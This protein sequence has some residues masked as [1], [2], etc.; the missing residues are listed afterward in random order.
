MAAEESTD[1]DNPCVL[2]GAAS[3]LPPN[4]LPGPR[5][6]ARAGFSEQLS[7]CWG[8]VGVTS[9][10]MVMK[11]LGL[12]VESVLDSSGLVRTL[13]AEL[14]HWKGICYEDKKCPTPSILRSCLPPKP[15]KCLVRVI[16]IA[17]SASSFLGKCFEKESGRT[18]LISGAA[19]DP[20]S[21]RSALA[22]SSLPTKRGYPLK[23]KG[24]LSLPIAGMTRHIKITGNRKV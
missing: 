18:S 15:V 2:P 1:E 13:W 23:G 8:F 22:P 10:A 3:C 20:L 12:A 11:H 7:S 14:N 9:P 16:Q 5:A 19:L 6:R 21:M 4:G 24:G 17:A